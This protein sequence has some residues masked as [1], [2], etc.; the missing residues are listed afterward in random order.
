MLKNIDKKAVI[1]NLAAPLT[2]LCGTL[3]CRG[4]P[5]GNHCSKGSTDCRFNILLFK[6]LNFLCT[7][8]KVKV[9]FE[10]NHAF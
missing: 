8:L 10:Q 2:P 7:C 3:V 6:K 9:R 4:T 5:V 1:P